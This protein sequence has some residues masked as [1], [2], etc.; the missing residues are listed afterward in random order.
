LAELDCD[1]GHAT[2]GNSS[3]T[4]NVYLPA[5]SYELRY[6]YSGRVDYP[7]YDPAYLCGSTA[8]D[9]GWA[10]DR[11]SAS[12]GVT[13]ALRTNQINVY[14]DANTNGTIPTHATIDG[15]EQLG[16]S[17]LID[18]CVYSQSWIERS[19]RINVSTAGYYWLSF[20]ADGQ[21]DSYG[22]QL[23]N[24][25][26]CNGTC[27]GSVQDNFPAAWT[28]TVLFEDT[29]ESPQYSGGFYSTNGNMGNSLGTSGAS[30]GWPAQAA[31]GW[32]N[33]PTNQLPY[34]LAGCP[35]ASQCIELGWGENS[36]VSRPFL[37]DPG[38]YRVTYDYIS[39]ITFS[40]LSGVYCGADPS[41]ANISTL[42]SHSGTGVIRVLNVTNP[43][44]LTEDTST[45]GVFMSHAQLASTPNLSTTLGATLTYTNPD[46]TVTAI[47]ANPPNSVSLTNYDPSQNNPLLDIC[48]Y[49]ASSQ[50]RTAYVLIQKPAYYW[51][52]F[53]A[54]GSADSF[55]GQIDDVKV[56]AVGSLYGV[57]PGA[58]VTIPVPTPANGTSYN[59]SGAFSGFSITADPLTVPAP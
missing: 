12:W 25:R 31:A 1:N 45:V 26:L 19:V 6:N 58:V 40:G 42:S 44:P 49:A 43:G 59:N 38:Y 41:S 16:G 33:A 53:A 30:S 47:A 14:L 17:N 4:A 36:L 32:A 46:G 9:L 54:L 39:E 55:G 56:T 50:Q 8:G 51:L 35:Q 7:N 48:G 27:A 52:T 20:A 37:L 10:N 21:N 15:T 18:M 24:I 11:K 57:A 2:A 3:I 5:G 22:G 34:W 23:D 13:N 28:G 29:F